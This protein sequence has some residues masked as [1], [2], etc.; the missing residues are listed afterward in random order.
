MMLYKATANPFEA[1]WQLD[2]DTLT[3]RHVLGN[4]HP[5]TLISVGNLAEDLRAI[6]QASLKAETGTDD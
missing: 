2:E 4:D 5:Q 6:A 1:A 3:R